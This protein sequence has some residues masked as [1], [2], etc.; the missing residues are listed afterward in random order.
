M[1][2]TDRLLDQAFDWT[3]ELKNRDDFLQVMREIDARVVLHGHFHRFQTYTSGGIEFIN[4]AV[5][6]MRQSASVLSG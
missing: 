6:G 5:S 4:G 3:M 2:G 1:Y